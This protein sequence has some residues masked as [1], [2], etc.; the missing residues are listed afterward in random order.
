MEVIII[1][2]KL[3]FFIFSAALLKTFYW[4]KMSRWS[5]N[6]ATLWQSVTL[7][8]FLV[9]CTHGG[10]ANIWQT[11]KLPDEHIP[12]FFNNNKDVKSLCEKDSKCPYKV[13]YL[14]KINT[15]FKDVNIVC[16]SFHLFY[17]VQPNKRILLIYL[18]VAII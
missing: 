1:L 15:T 11:L 17:Y 10:K 9:T 8:L 14:G 13:R 3:L 2:I 18:R 7:V 16:C 6:R 12:Y 5:I 4:L